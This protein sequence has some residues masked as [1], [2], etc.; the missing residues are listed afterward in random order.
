M[1]TEPA[2]T[3]REVPA[4]VVPRGKLTPR[5]VRWARRRRALS[6]FWQQFRQS[7]MGIIGLAILLFYAGVAM[8]SI[9]A[10]KGALDPTI[11]TNGPRLAGPSLA[12]PLGTQIDGISVLSLTIEGAR[13]SLFV[14]L[15]A[16]LISMLLGTIIGMW[17]G[18]KSSVHDA[19]LMRITD[20]F[21]VLPW[22]A[23]AIVLAAMFGQNFWIII[24]IIG[25]TSWAGT[26][27]LVR[28]QVLSV[29]ERTYIERSRALGASDAHVVIKHITPNLMPIIFAN[30]ILTIAIAILSESQLSFLGLGDPKSQSWGTLIEQAFNHGA[31]TLHA[32]WW[33]MAPSLSIVFVVLGFTMVGFA[34]DEIL[35]PRIRER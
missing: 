8:F 30:T 23:L 18:Y 13:I 15:A 28:A 7:K 2:I 1:K 9:F 34:M 22:L 20:V 6:R 19:I 5:Q 35:N 3:T 12:Y 29:K 21:L 17:A 25:L 33:L 11:T 4:P 10:N 24:I 31:L 27:R 32:W 26:A 14:G 16:A